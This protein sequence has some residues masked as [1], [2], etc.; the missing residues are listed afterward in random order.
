MSVSSIGRPVSRALVVVTLAGASFIVPG[1]AEAAPICGN[2]GGQTICVAVPSG[3]LSGPATITITNS[4]NTGTLI[5]RWIPSGKSAIQLITEFGPSPSTND[6][7]FVWPT[8]KYLDDSGV[9]RVQAG[10]TSSSP[11]DV[12]VSLSNGNTSDFQH[13]PN[14][15]ADFLPDPSWTASRDP[16]VAAVGDGASNDPEANDN[17]DAIAASNPDLFLYLG[18][19][20]E[21]GTATE[22]LNHYGQ[23]SMDGGPGTLWGQMADITQPAIGDHEVSNRDAWRD[24]FHGRPLYTSFVFGNVLF[25]D[26]ASTGE[27]MAVGSP[28]YD[29]VKSILTSSSAPACVVSYF[30]NPALAK[31]KIKTKNGRADMWA[32]LTDNGGDLV[33]NGNTHTMLQY[34]PLN[35]K[36]QLPS[37][38]QAT[39]VE[40]IAGSGGH[41]MGGTFTGDSRVEWS[42]GKTPGAVYIT[43]NGAADG[44][45]PT[46]LSWAYKDAKGNVLHTGS[47]DCGGGSPP[48]PP[49]GLSITGFSPTSGPVGTSVQITGT[50]FTGTSDVSFGGASATSYTVD[51]DS[52]IT[53]TVPASASTGPISVT[54]GAGTATS[55]S[56]FTVT[57]SGG[58]GGLAISGF[59]PTSGPVGTSV[60]I[61]GSGFSGVTVVKFNGVKAHFTVDSDAQITATVPSSATSGPIKVK[62]PAGA[63]TSASD[64]TVSSGGGGGGT[65]AISG[66]SPTSGPVGSSVTITGSAFSGVTI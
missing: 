19:I 14:D 2:S 29:W 51:T 42:K 65:L 16:V 30:Q 7:T 52:Q 3:T 44:G 61:A 60:T 12:P 15:W 24:Y 25:L 26:L 21:D 41:K 20:Y 4:A 17:A 43:L 23:S 62:D 39:Q 5:A 10:S 36:L 22:N 53:A 40:L 18:D 59:T 54:T 11:V 9:L 57:S 63:V 27:S 46:S 58:G 8:Q 32:L 28:Q 49:P 38:G 37:S 34:K 33:L 50:G 13:A 47:R 31:D 48:P 55:S 35:D 66:F 64:F 1:V 45:S 6:Y 56:A